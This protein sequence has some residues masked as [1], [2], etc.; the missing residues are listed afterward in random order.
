[1]KANEII[2]LGPGLEIHYCLDAADTD[3]QFTMF[4]V[5][6]HPDA[7]VPAAHYHDNFDET[8]MGIRGSLT[9]R[10]D[11]EQFQLVPGE[12]RF[13]KRGQ[14][15]GFHNE[16]DETVEFLAFA[17]PGIFT[18]NYFRDLRTVLTAGGPPD[19]AKL[20]EVM[21]SHGLIPSAG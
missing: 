17:V 2:D 1:M 10:V 16:T 11:E 15:H 8:F 19:K 4:K 13:I 18:A 20:K 5:I 9:V 3:S 14:V 6:V 21:L 7:K 12:H